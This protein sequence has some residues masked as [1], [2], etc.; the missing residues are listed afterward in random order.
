MIMI[1]IE[2]KKSYNAG[3]DG[4]ETIFTSHSYN[5]NCPHDIKQ[6]YEEKI[7]DQKFVCYGNYYSNE[8]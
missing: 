8:F 3:D 1:I 4:T 2:S 6:D 7:F 5:S